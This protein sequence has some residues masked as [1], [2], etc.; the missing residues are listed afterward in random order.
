MIIETKIFDDQTY[1]EYVLEV[2]TL[3][4]KHGGRYLAR[5]G[6]VV[7]FVGGWDPERIIVIEFGS[8]N[9]W[10]KCFKSAEYLKIAPLRENSVETRA[11][12][13]EGC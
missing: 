5:G 4:E 11:I 13:V 12:V 10:E 2:K 3:V 8:M 9:E 1:S 6:K 7:P